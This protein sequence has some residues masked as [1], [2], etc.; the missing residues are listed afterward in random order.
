MTE[1][2]NYGA[3]VAL[4]KHFLK[5]IKHLLS[6][7]K[8]NILECYSGK[9]RRIYNEC[10]STENT[11]SLD[12]KG[13]KGIIKINNRKFIAA[14]TLEFDYFDLDAYGSPYE[15]LL[16]IFNK[17]GKINTLFVV[18]LTDGLWQ[19]LNYGKGSN[20]IKT[21]I[22]NKAN[23]SIPALNRHHDFI[24]KLLFKTFSDKFNIKIEECKIVRDADNQMR[25]LGLLCKPL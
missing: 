22:N 11:T 21:V 17:R 18:I 4:R 19:K 7:D 14:H 5:T 3:K 20:L 23:I 24:I 2:T 12:K 16:N 8:I 9:E 15:L 25:Y 6:T 1:H 10:Y 13:G